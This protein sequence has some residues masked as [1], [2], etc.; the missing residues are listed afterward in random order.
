MK[1]RKSLRVGGFAVNPQIVVLGI[2]ILALLIYPW[3]FT[4]PFSRHLIITLL[5]Y[6]TMGA[7]WNILAGYAGQISVGHAVY[8]GL[9][10][11]TSTVLLMKLGLTPWL[12]MFGGVVVAE[13]VALIVGYPCFRLGGRY[14]SMATLVI[15]EI[16]RIM[17]TNW[18]FVDA[19]VGLFLPIL[20][21]SFL[22]F[23]FHSSKIPYYYIILTFTAIA[24]VTTRLIEKSRLGY[25][26]RA[27]RDD[28]EAARSLGI[29]ITKYK[30]LALA[31]SVFFT[32]IAGTVYAQYVLFIDPVST[33]NFMMSL[34]ITLVVILGG[35]G[36]L[37][38]PIIGAFV[39]IPVTEL[40][41]VYWGGMGQ[42]IDLIIY[43]AL[44]VIIAIYQPRGL[45][46]MVERYRR[47]LRYGGT[48]G[49][50]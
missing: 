6:A 50:D 30:L 29:N 32:S 48:A 35:M 1:G 45:V 42:A 14:F 17:F 31:F 21:E 27:I 26:F 38:G 22:N 10:A 37:W 46:S 19:A 28:P 33:M 15:G 13:L 11:Y 39:L 49:S 18:K 24:V 16:A 44:I 34:M 47:K 40:T 5:M 43:G 4:D 3:I 9:G 12:G 23:Q 8:F 2:V 41:R 36:T 7:G 25:Y 20:E